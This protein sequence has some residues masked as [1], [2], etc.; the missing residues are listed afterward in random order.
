MKFLSK[1]LQ[2]A[3][4][5]LIIFF[6]MESSLFA[7][8]D[9]ILINESRNVVVGRSM[10]FGA[11]LESQIVIFPRNEK[12]VSKIKNRNGLSWTSKYAYVAITSFKKDLVADGMNEKGLSLG[13]LWFHNAKYPKIPSNVRSKTIAL[14]DI[15]NWILGSFANVSE[16]KTAIQ[17][18]Y[19]WAHVLKELKQIIPIHFSLHDSSGRN[20]VIEFVDGKMN[21]IDN[22]VGV[23]TNDP[24]FDWHVTNLSNYINLTAINKGEVVFDGS[25]IDPTGQGTGLL[26]LPGDWTPPSRFVKIAILKNFVKKTKTPEENINLAFHLLNTVDIAYGVVRSKEGS[27]FD[28]TQW[29]VVKDLVNKKLSY[30]TYKDLN[31]HTIDLMSE[32]GKL[33][34]ERKIIPMIGAI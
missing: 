31:I 14:E 12:K 5:I 32:I 19:I 33:N 34:S 2:S 1:T 27:H 20:I 13:T 9:F 11:N 3:L 8:T 30:R 21:I 24:A 23:L 7:C 22:E 17:K 10:E 25:A 16:V 26:G 6:G 15:G 28:H 18:I 4:F 29:V